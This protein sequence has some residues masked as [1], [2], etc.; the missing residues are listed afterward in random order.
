M[1]WVLHLNGAIDL[2]DPNKLIVTKTLHLPEDKIS[3]N[4]KFEIKALAVG[5][6]VFNRIFGKDAKDNRP[7]IPSLFKEMSAKGL[8]PFLDKDPEVNK[9]GWV[10][11]YKTGEGMATEYHI[12]P[13][14]TSESKIVDGEELTKTVY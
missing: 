9:I 1:V 8:N 2:V 14:S 10:K 4:A 3:A 6:A 7:A 11:L 13:C 12:V 5:P